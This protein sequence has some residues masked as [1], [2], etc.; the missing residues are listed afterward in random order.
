MEQTKRKQFCYDSLGL[1][2]CQICSSSLT[3]E[4][5]WKNHMSHHHGDHLPFKCNLCTKGYFSK[6]GLESHT[7]L[8]KGNVFQCP[9][10]DKTTT[11]KFSLNRHLRKVHRSAQCFSCMEVY[12][13]AQSK[14]H[15]CKS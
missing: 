13:E 3:H 4:L 11:R 7:Q 1:I 8:H 5:D 14:D 15:I 10:C 6:S 12:H 9:I 2:Q